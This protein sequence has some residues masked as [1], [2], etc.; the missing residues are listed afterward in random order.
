VDDVGKLDAEED[1]LRDVSGSAPGRLRRRGAPRARRRGG[2]NHIPR[3]R[4]RR[5]GC[6]LAEGLDDDGSIHDDRRRRRGI[7]R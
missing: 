3:E 1:A 5:R 6:L 4:R 2:T 7:A